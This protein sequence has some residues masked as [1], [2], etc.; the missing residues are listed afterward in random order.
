MSVR[1]LAEHLESQLGG[2]SFQR[3]NNFGLDIIG[4]PG[5]GDAD[6]ISLSVESCFAPVVGSEVHQ[7]PF[8]NE[9]VYY[10]GRAIPRPGEMV[11]RD[12]LDRQVL[13]TMLNWRRLVYDETTGSVGLGSLYKKTAFLV[14]FGPNSRDGAPTFQRRWLIK[15]IW[16]SEGNPAS[17]GLTQNSSAHVTSGW[18][19]YFDKAVPQDGLS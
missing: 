14:L 15:G 17:N 16:P 1:V 9:V 2:F 5:P 19:L 18:T 10:A 3:Q 8:G 12:F 4:L 13:A 7:A 11:L 6:L